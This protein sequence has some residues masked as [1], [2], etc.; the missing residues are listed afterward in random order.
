MLD[1]ET[2]TVYRVRLLGGN[3]NDDDLTAVGA[4]EFP[5]AVI[6]HLMECEDHDCTTEADACRYAIASV[7]A[8]PFWLHALKVESREQWSMSD[9]GFDHVETETRLTVLFDEIRSDKVP[10]EITADGCDELWRMLVDAANVDPFAVSRGEALPPN[11]MA[12]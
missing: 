3:P 10:F 4:A 11:F 5:G 8:D 1:C 6:T 12:E 2:K 9:D 7:G